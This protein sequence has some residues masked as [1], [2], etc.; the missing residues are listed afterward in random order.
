MP[1]STTAWDP[2]L[3][4]VLGHRTKHYGWLLSLSYLEYIGYRKMIKSLGYEHLNKGS[5]HHLSDEIQHSFML[6][7]LAQKSF[8]Q[9]WQSGFSLDSIHQISE[10]YFQNL[11][12]EVHHKVLAV[13][14]QENPVLCYMLTSYVIEKRAMKVYPAYL[15]KSSEA[16]VKYTLQKII[17]DESEHLTYLEGK[18][19]LVP[20]FSSKDLEDLLEA[21]EKLFQQYLAK[22]AMQLDQ[23][24]QSN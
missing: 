14:P 6:R 22:M 20:S 5:F 7:E 12:H 9:E 3:E 17:R 8:H 21:E 10:E 24:A 15:A 16:P 4:E 11:D 13:D 19:S 23:M 1:A 2:F 18:I